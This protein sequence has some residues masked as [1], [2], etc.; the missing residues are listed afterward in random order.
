MTRSYRE[1]HD[2]EHAALEAFAKCF[3]RNKW[4]AT[5]TDIYWYNAASMSTA[6]TR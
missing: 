1:L 2:Y 3:G 4:R 6:T 5:L